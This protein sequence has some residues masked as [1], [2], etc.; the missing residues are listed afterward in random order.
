MGSVLVTHDRGPVLRWSLL[1]VS[2]FVLQMGVVTDF[3]LFGVHPDLMLLVAICGGLAGGPS[4]GAV[5]GFCAGLLSDL[6][7]SGALG[8]TAL[9]FALV[10][11]GAGAAAQSLIRST[12]LISLGLTAV[13]SVAG[14]LLY[15]ATA[16]LLGQRT[17]SDPRLWSIVGIVSVCNVALCLP[18]LGLARWAEGSG[19]RSGLA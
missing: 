6:L 1:V 14:V 16:Q 17:L 5:V 7:L 19:L 11:F 18:A 4:R 10:G 15:A 3:E 2:V 8:V 9:A 13:A 12:R